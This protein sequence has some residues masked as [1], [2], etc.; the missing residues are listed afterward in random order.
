MSHLKGG[1]LRGIR[2]DESQRF[3]HPPGFALSSLETT[4]KNWRNPE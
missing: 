3:A 2:D 1:W 4:L